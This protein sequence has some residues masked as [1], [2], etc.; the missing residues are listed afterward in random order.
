MLDEGMLGTLNETHYRFPG[1]VE[2]IVQSGYAVSNAPGFNGSCCFH[3]SFPLRMKQHAN[4]SNLEA[5]RYCYQQQS[6]TSEGES[7][8][9]PGFVN[10]WVDALF[11]S[12]GAMPCPFP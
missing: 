6:L 3:L 10:C 12:V 5:K 7:Q 8:I 1:F 11:F 4:A 2:L 9:D